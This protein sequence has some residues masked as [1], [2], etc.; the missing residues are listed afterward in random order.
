MMNTCHYWKEIGTCFFK[1]EIDIV[2]TYMKLTND[3][4]LMY[5]VVYVFLSS[6]SIISSYF[7]LYS[8]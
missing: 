1:E 4:N 2:V 7:N 3:Y 8:S 5:L 6:S